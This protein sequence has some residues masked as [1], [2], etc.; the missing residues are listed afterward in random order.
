MNCH[1]HHDHASPG[2]ADHLARLKGTLALSDVHHVG[3]IVADRDKAL[4]GLGELFVGEPYRMDAVFPPARFRTGIETTSL[5]LGFVW[6]GNLLVEILQPTDDQSVQGRYLKD[7]G[8][9]LHHLGFI[10]PSIDA[11]LAALGRDREEAILADG[12][13]P[14][15]DLKWV[16][17]DSQIIP[18]VVVE[19]IERSPAAEQFFQGIYNVTGGQLPA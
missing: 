12:T 3:V 16:Y 5:R 19:L 7:R 1:L 13:I 8:E 2:A 4:A 11:H 6:A 17:L 15:N 14:G 10:V 9:G 18:G